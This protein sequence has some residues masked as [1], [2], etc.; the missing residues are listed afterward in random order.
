MQ[1]DRRARFRRAAP[2]TGVLAE[3]SVQEQVLTVVAAVP[4][5][6]IAGLTVLAWRPLRRW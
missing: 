3:P 1:L 5:L 6:A 2:A 4:D